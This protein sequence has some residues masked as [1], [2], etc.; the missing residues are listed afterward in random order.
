MSD[1]SAYPVDLKDHAKRPVFL[2]RIIFMMLFGFGLLAY[3]AARLLGRPVE[4]GVI[5]LA[6]QAAHASAGYAIMH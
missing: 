3:S 4:G 6:R 5:H 2:Y 1:I